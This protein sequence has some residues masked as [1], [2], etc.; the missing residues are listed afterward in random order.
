LISVDRLFHFSPPQPSA[1]LPLRRATLCAPMLRRDAAMLCF[2]SLRCAALCAMPATLMS[3]A[4][5]Q[6]RIY[7]A[8]AFSPLAAADFFRHAADFSPGTSLCELA[9]FSSFLYLPLAVSITTM[10]FSFHV[11]FIFH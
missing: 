11:F 3:D 1:P 4:A 5:F 10:L 7:A 2:I 8:S 6:R 9:F